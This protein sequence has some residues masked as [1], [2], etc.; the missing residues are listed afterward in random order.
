LFGR[1]EQI[2]DAPGRIPKLDLDNN[3][4]GSD[5]PS[6][7]QSKSHLLSGKIVDFYP[8]NL[9]GIWGGKISLVK[10]IACDSFAKNNPTLAKYESD[11]FVP[12]LT[13]NMNFTFKKRHDRVQLE[14]PIGLFEIPLRDTELADKAR[15]LLAKGSA[16]YLLEGEGVCPGPFRAGGKGSPVDARIKDTR[17][18]DENLNSTKTAFSLRPDF[19]YSHG[20]TLDGQPSKSYVI[21][22]VLRQLDSS[23]YEQDLV[24]REITGRQKKESYSEWV[25][26][27]HQ[28]PDGETISFKILAN[29]FD[30]EGQFTEE[31]EFE[32]QVKHG[33]ATDTAVRYVTIQRHPYL[34]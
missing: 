34:G 32:G 8:Q 24:S 22:N 4:A 7:D 25:V 31:T 18:T 5:I 1:I 12:G 26:R 16:A 3:E 21:K 28:E 23:T 33:T 2:D 6:I 29:G 20:V 14:P 15:A 19:R 17:L 27:L 9:S 30:A 13:G 10:R 11:A